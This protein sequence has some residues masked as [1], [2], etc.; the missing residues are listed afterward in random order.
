MRNHETKE[1][2][3]KTVSELKGGVWLEVLGKAV[4]DR[5]RVVLDR[6]SPKHILGC[7]LG[8]YFQ[9]PQP[10]R[11]I[12]RTGLC[13]VREITANIYTTL[14][15]WEQDSLQQCALIHM[16]SPCLFNTKNRFELSDFFFSN[17]VRVPPAT[18]V[19]ICPARFVRIENLRKRTVSCETREHRI[20]INFLL[21][22]QLL[23]QLIPS[24]P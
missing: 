8:R 17:S 22:T 18:V 15:C 20:W 11:S 6:K 3:C 19:P 10:W 13:Q 2:G 12:A 14:E 4:C 24:C 7:V 21:P 9:H 16:S 23:E 5:G 1:R